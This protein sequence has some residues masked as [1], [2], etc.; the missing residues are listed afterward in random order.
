[1]SFHF[2]VTNSDELAAYPPPVRRQLVERALFMLNSGSKLARWLQIILILGGGA[3]GAVAM[4]CVDF[5]HSRAEAVATTINSNYLGGG[6]GCAVGALAWLC[7]R[8]RMLRPYLRMAIED[9]DRRT[10]HPG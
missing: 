1:M 5:P 10:T 2:I 4:Y 8:R 9:Y 7:L 6:A 3:V